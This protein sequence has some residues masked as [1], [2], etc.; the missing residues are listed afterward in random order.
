MPRERGAEPGAVAAVGK[1]THTH[2]EKEREV[3]VG[4]WEK[5]KRHQMLAEEG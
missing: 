2:T 5:A 1:H 3:Q 4:R